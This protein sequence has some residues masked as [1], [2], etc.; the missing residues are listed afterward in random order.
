MRYLHFY[1]TMYQNCK[2]FFL[3]KIKLSFM[4]DDYKLGFCIGRVVS[5]H[6]KIVPSGDN[7]LLSVIVPFISKHQAFLYC[8]H[9]AFPSHSDNQKP[10]QIFPKHPLL[11][12]AMPIESHCCPAFL[13]QSSIRD[14]NASHWVALFLF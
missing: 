13:R 9:T 4:L 3:C 11:Y 7:F 12:G 6:F 14:L 5:G 10:P 1:K 2:N 8:A